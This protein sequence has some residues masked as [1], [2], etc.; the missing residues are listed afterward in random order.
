MV[1]EIHIAWYYSTLQLSTYNETY[2]SVGA[3]IVEM[4]TG[5]MPYKNEKF[6]NQVAIIFQVGSN[7]IDPLISM[8]KSSWLWSPTV[9]RILNRCFK[10]YYSM[11][12]LVFMHFM[13]LM[14]CMYIIVTV[15][16]RTD[17]QLLTYWECMYE[18]RTIV[19]VYVTCTHHVP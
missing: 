10:R 14:H 12:M 7:K 3:T 1:S 2:R 9:E 13:T 11:I 6:D 18:S 19:I 15:M 8:K 4:L 17:P 16:Q 5:E